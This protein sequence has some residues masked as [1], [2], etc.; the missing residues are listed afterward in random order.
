MYM[1]GEIRSVVAATDL[2]PAAD[3]TIEVTAQIARR[4]GA[5]LHVVHAVGPTPASSLRMLDAGTG[6]T[7]SSRSAGAGTPALELE[8]QLART[9]REGD[10]FVPALV[11][12]H[13]PAHAISAHANEMEADLIVIG[14][15]GEGKTV[16][17]VL[18]T[19]ADMVLR[20][21]DAAVLVV[22]EPRVV[23]A[24][25]VM[26]A[27]DPTEPSAGVVRVALE[28][29]ALFGD[30][31]T[32]GNAVLVDAVHVVSA[33]VAGALGFDGATAVRHARGDALET[34]RGVELREFEV[35]GEDIATLL[36]YAR[37]AGPELLVAGS[38][39]RGALKRALLGATSSALASR[40]PCSVLLL[41]PRMWV[42]A[43]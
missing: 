19:T 1:V 39:G 35:R 17:G 37:E 36:E 13:S 5:R 20:S 16:G 6:S 41:P 23:P 22:R 33:S 14:T 40:A 18:R 32:A 38:R 26:V 15:P 28:W 25:R 11:P 27:V 42:G 10:P 3:R 9:L 43:G 31:P 29:A 2:S 24:R 7:G 8:A 4:L 12:G 34:P 21:A 30:Q